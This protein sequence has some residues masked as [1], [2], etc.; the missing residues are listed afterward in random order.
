MADLKN[1]NAIIKEIQS[2]KGLEIF[3]N[4]NFTIDSIEPDLVQWSPDAIF[5]SSGP[6]SQKGFEILKYQSG[7]FNPGSAAVAVDHIAGRRILF[8]F[9]LE[10]VTDP[11]TLRVLLTKSI[12]WVC[13]TK[14]MLLKRYLSIAAKNADTNSVTLNNTLKSMLKRIFLDI[15]L[16]EARIIAK[17]I[18]GLTAQ[19]SITPGLA[20]YLTPVIS[21]LIELEK[22]RPDKYKG[23]TEILHTEMPHNE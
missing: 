18:K 7:S 22:V 16:T 20:I 10:A 5:I 14:K 2:A 13:F 1:D 19:K 6:G 17:S 4:L 21:K 12:D 9:G 3:E 23:I 11:Q 15:S 8:A